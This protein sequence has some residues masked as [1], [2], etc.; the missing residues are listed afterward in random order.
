MKHSIIAVISVLAVMASTAYAITP[1]ES[2]ADYLISNQFTTP[3]GYAGGWGWYAGETSPT[4]NTTGSTGQG[5][6]HAYELTGNTAYLDSAKAA[7]NY[8]MSPRMGF[9]PPK[10]DKTWFAAADPYFC[11]R[12]SVASSD[13]TWSNLAATEFFDELSAGTY[14]TSNRDTANWISALQTSRSGTLINARPWDLATLAVTAKNI[15]NTGQEGLFKQAILDGLNT[16]DNTNPASVWYDLIGLAGGVQGLA[17]D[18]VTSFTPINSPNQS[19]ING[20]S[21]LADLANYLAGK[22][23]TDGSWYWST[24]LAS[25]DLS[26]ESTQETAYSVLALEAVEQALG[27]SIYDGEIALGQSFLIS[28]Q[29]TSGGFLSYPGQTTAINLEVTGEAIAAI[30]EPGTLTLLSLAGLSGLAMVWIRRRRL[31][32]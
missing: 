1:W 20:I 22:Q 32:G 6:I 12:L 23:N 5:M 25:P 16:L 26:D 27:V 14:G 19:G 11:W 17:L 30:P 3:A 10:A 8:L 7:G 9:D 15:G 4:Y 13:N 28:M 2:G 31:S 29:D 24:N 18:G 21:T